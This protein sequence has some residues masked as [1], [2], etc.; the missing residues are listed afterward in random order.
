M[1]LVENIN[2][3]YRQTV[4]ESQ[5]HTAEANQALGKVLQ[6]SSTIT[7]LNQQ[8][9]RLASDQATLATT[10]QKQTSALMQTTDHNSVQAKNTDQASQAVKRLAERY[11]QALAKYQINHRG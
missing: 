4:L 9:S 5:Q 11:Q 2:N 10:M 7:Q 3:E 1:V 8:I 6:A